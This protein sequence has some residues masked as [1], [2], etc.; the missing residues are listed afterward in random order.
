[1]GRLNGTQNCKSYGGKPAVN[2]YKNIYISMWDHG[3]E[4]PDQIFAETAKLNG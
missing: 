2:K 1:M 4:D 3:R